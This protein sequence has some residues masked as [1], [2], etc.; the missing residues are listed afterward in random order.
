MIG[1]SGLVVSYHTFWNAGEVPARFIDIYPNQDFLSY[2]ED[3][4]RG[5]KWI[6][7]KGLA[8]SS[9]E[10][11]KAINDLN[12]KFGITFFPE[13]YPPLIRSTD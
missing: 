1:T 8:F 2:F 7:E 13:L 4:V 12:E 3:G 11:Q 10:V 9:P 5:R 6:K